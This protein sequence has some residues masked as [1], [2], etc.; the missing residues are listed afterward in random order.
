MLLRSS[1]PYRRTSRFY[2]HS[3][4]RLIPVFILL[5]ALYDLYSTW[6]APPV[7]R[8]TI[9]NSTLDSSSP[10]PSI[11]NSVVITQIPQQQQRVFIASIQWNAEPFLRQ[12][13]NTALL[14]LVRHFGPQNVY[15]SILEGGSW[16][17]TRAALSQ[18]DVDLERLGVE[19]SIVYEDRTHEDEVKR[20]P[21]P[22][23]E[24]WVWTSRGMKELRR[25]PF[26]AGLRNRVMGVMRGLAMR[27]GERKRVF[28]KV[29]WLNDV[30]FT[31]C[32]S[33][34][35]SYV[36]ENMEIIQVYLTDWL[37]IIML[38]YRPKTLR[39]C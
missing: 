33:F 16:D 18:L 1:G 12:H 9:P 3:R 6:L 2:R 24:G 31:V 8:V 35:D 37:M 20:T 17:N 39:R 4:V 19:R 29:L 7:Y 23:E 30:I 14:K 21:A 25:I 27:E 15:V 5:V 22:G 13:W 32:F 34:L 28:D 11:S 36:T 10:S 26:M 38:P